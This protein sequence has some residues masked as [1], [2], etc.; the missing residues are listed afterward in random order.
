MYAGIPAQVAVK[1]EQADVG[2]IGLRRRG[3]SES[4]IAT[5]L[6]RAA[7]RVLRGIHR[8][9]L[10]CAERTRTDRRVWAISERR[11]LE[12]VVAAGDDVE[13][14][15]GRNLDDGSKGPVAKELAAKAAAAKL[16]RLVDAAEDEA[17]TLVK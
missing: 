9:F 4:L 1:R 16:A 7:R 11:Q 13:G 8:I 2:K 15:A 5:L 3:G 10:R 6:Q 17:V 12:V 14:A